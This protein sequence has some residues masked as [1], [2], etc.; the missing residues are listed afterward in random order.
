MTLL[1]NENAQTDRYINELIRNYFSES[2]VQTAMSYDLTQ[3]DFL[4]E[5]L[6]DVRIIDQEKDFENWF[7]SVCRIF[8]EKNN[9]LFQLFLNDKDIVLLGVYVENQLVSTTMMF[10]QGEVAGLHLVGTLNEYRG[11]G[12]GS[13]ITKFALK[14]ATENG[15]KFCVLQASKMGKRVYR[16]IGFNEY[17]KISH[18]NYQVQ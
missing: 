5:D 8:G 4:S 11:K 6:Q 14:Y 2:V 16:R 9:K 10:M 12:L 15:C 17:E 1:I 13:L 18:W 3:I 7:N